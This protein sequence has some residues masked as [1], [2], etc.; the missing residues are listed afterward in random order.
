MVLETAIEGND[1]AARSPLAA[2]LD[3]PATLDAFWRQCHACG[4]AEISVAAAIRE[5]I[6]PQLEKLQI[7]S[8]TS[9]SSFSLLRF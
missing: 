2:V 5:I 7:P 3:S 8:A 1:T 6:L 9:R 4:S